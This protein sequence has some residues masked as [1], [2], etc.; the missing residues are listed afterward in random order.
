MSKDMEYY[1]D[2]YRQCTNEFKTFCKEHYFL[3]SE[4]CL[5]VNLSLS[6]KESK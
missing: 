6:G 4:D 1:N 5:K 2:L 3:C